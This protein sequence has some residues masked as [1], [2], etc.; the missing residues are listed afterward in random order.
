LRQSLACKTE[1]RWSCY[2]HGFSCWN[3][4]VEPKI[5]VTKGEGAPQDQDCE[6]LG[7]G[8]IVA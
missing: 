4:K 8:R 2:Q 7:K 3:E 5:G 6:R 1:K